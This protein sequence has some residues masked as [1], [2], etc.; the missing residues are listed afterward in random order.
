MACML[1]YV[2]LFSCLWT[3]RYKT[4]QLQHLAL[5]AQLRRVR[6]AINATN[7]TRNGTLSYSELIRVS[8]LVLQGRYLRLL[9]FVQCSC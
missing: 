7:A 2:Y 5:V 9:V 6:A 4:R 1:V 3:L 8:V